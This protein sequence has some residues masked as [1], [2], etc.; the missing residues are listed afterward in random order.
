MTMIEVRAKRKAKARVESR[1]AKE[2]RPKENNSWIMSVTGV[3]SVRI[4]SM[5]QE[6]SEPP[7][8]FGVK[9]SI[10]RAKS[11]PL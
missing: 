7:E 3:R 10:F 6:C 1:T 4:T 5:K 11:L 9:Y 2:S 8:A